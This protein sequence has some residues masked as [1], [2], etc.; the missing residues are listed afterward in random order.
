[1]T[2]GKL[3]HELKSSSILLNKQTLMKEKEVPCF[4]HLYLESLNKIREI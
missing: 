2:L 4:E 1:M 3:Y